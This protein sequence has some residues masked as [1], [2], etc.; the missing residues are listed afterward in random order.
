VV[1]VVYAVAPGDLSER[2]AT[3]VQEPQLVKVPDIRRAKVR[4]GF[5]EAS[6]G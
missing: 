3:S 4:A 2:S 5:R 6:L 1:R